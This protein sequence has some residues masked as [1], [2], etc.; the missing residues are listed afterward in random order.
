MFTL[1]P[2]RVV[3]CQKLVRM[4][5]LERSVDVRSNFTIQCV[6]LFDKGS[7]AV[8]V[9]SSPNDGMVVRASE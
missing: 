6:V 4:R 8:V 3:V 5:H 7:D 2:P 1:F 9:P